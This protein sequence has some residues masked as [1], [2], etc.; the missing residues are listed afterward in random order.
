LTWRNDRD[1]AAAE[2]RKRKFTAGAGACL[3]CI[4]EAARLRPILSNYTFQA[5]QTTG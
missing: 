4:K 5:C 3:T 2:N 1:L